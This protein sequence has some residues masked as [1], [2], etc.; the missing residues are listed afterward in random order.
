MA[1]VDVGRPDPRIRDLADQVE[2][3]PLDIVEGKAF[4][5]QDVHLDGREF[6]DCSFQYCRIIV[7]LGRFA[8]RGRFRV[9][10]CTF[11]LEGPAQGVKTIFDALDT[12]SQEDSP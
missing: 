1:D 12:Q 2:L 5:A 7:R 9:E 11:L 6:I 8:V 10:D 4:L 3:L